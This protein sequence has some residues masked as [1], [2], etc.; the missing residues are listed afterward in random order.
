MSRRTTRPRRASR[1]RTASISATLA[2]LFVIALVYLFQRF[3]NIDF[4]LIATATPP[5]PTPASE[6]PTSG[7]WYRLYFTNPDPNNPTGGIPDKIAESFNAAQRTLDLAIYELDLPVLSEAL[8]AASRRGVRVRVVTDSDSLSE[9]PIQDLMAAGIPV[10]DDQRDPIM[11]DKFVVID[12]SIVWTGSMNFTTN[13]AYRNN[14]NFIQITSTRL[15]QNYT[16][17]FEEM[18]TRREFGPT[19]TANTPNP[20]ITINN[21]LLE[22]YFSSEDGVAALV[23]D[24]L[25]SAQSSIYFMAFSFTRTDFANALIEKAQAGLPVQGVFETRQIAAGGDAAWNA[26]TTAGVDVRQDGNPYLLHSKVFIIDQQIVI[27]GSYNFSRNA[28]ENNDENILIIHNPEI[29]AA[30]FA[31]WQKVWAQANP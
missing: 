21:T 18:F 29:A 26:L 20:T 14:N 25:Q 1:R 13:D 23:L 15:A 22:N 11:H 5:L 8:I 4:G 6:V 10:V 12:S 30:Y 2:L 24:V 28:E 3:T 16:T 31:E 7:T 9:E 17:E 27:T 19:S